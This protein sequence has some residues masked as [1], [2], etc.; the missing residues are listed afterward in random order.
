MSFPIRVLNVA[1]KPS[2]AREVSRILSNGQ[3]RSASSWSVSPPCARSTLLSSM[4]YTFGTIKTPLT[5]GE[6]CTGCSA[7]YN[8]VSEFQYQIGGQAC[9]MVFTS[10]AGHLMELEFED[11]YRR[12]RGVDPVDLYSALVF[13]KVPQVPAVLVAWAEPS[14]LPQTLPCS[15]FP[16]HVYCIQASSRPESRCWRKQFTCAS[17]QHPRFA[18]CFGTGL[19]RTRWTLSVTCSS[20]RARRLGWSCG[21]IATEKAKI[22]ALR[23]TTA[24][25]CVLW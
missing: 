1:E 10:V 24:M 8:P 6:A 16:R 2:V 11:G 23:C 18:V 7:R 15:Y 22:S 17:M 5:E 20:S 14:N 9:D 12:W 21:W 19:R 13:K 25:Q 4:R 3:S